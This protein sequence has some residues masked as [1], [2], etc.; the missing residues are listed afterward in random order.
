MQKK[1]L[2]CRKKQLKRTA[3]KKYGRI[4]PTQQRRTF[5]GSYS[6]DFGYLFLWFNTDDHSTHIVKTKIK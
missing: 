5:R 2:I 1:E 3:L 4:Y 6:E